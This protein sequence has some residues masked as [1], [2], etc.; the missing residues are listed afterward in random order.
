MITRRKISYP[1]AGPFADY[2]K[3]YERISDIP[4]IYEQ[5]L[6]FTGGIPYEAPDGKETL[7]LTVMYTPELMEELRPKLAKIYAIL[8]SGGAS[9][10]AEHLIVDRIDFGEFGNSRP[11][12]IRITNRFNDNSD[13]FYVKRADA[14]RLFGLELE[15]LLSPERINYLVRD[16]T[17]IEEH[18]AGLP[19]DMF[20]NSYMKRPDLNRVRLA[21]E[22]V[23]FNERCFIRLLGDMRSVNYVV[24]ITPDFEEVQFRVRPIDFD[25]QSYNGK[26]KV[27]LAYR[28]DSNRPVNQL[29]VECLNRRTISQYQKE[30]R[31]QMGRRAV[32]EQRRLNML[33]S[34]MRQTELAPQENV[35]QLRSELAELHKSKLFEQAWTMGD[36]VATNIQHFIY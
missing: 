16:H 29:V 11:F 17:L 12:R 2:L 30:E 24:D 15:H 26:S 14:S 19:G 3:H 9:G 20:I 8:K 21:K 34:V 32:A 22:F 28:F 27:Y 10:P 36:L 31:A 5:L 4:P 1:V 13:Y 35:V 33:L 7:W 23:K 6:G 25:Q 18:I